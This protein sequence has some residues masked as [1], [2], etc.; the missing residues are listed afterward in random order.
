MH[1]IKPLNSVKTSAFK[2]FLAGS[3]DMGKAEDW[4]TRVADLLKNKS[5]ILFNPRRD[6]W[7]SSWEQDIENINFR[8]QVK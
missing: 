6:D 4:Q 3:I 1:V 2:I 8:N 7:D 5:V